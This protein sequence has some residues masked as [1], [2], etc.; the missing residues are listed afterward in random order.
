MCVLQFE[1]TVLHRNEL[2]NY[3]LCKYSDFCNYPF[4]FFPSQ[5]AFVL[6]SDLLLIF[7]PQMI[8]GG[9]DF[10]RPLV[11]FPEAT[12]QSELA[13]F[14]MDHV[15]LQPGELGSG[16]RTL[17]PELRKGLGLSLATVSW[18]EG[19]NLW[20]VLFLL[21]RSVPRG[22]CPDRA[23]APTAPPACRV[24]QTAAL[25]STRARRSLRRFQTL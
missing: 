4:F 14:L 6:L 8:T 12:L 7:S 2:C 5:Q 19:L 3:N 25:W 1:E 9:R 11:F 24:L 23:P 22:S 16:T 15:F 13:S 20:L 17:G 10:L 21:H 18:V